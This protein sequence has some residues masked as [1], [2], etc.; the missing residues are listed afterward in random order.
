[1]SE[2]EG[3]RSFLGRWS[4]RKR[5]NEQVESVPAS[6]PVEADPASE[7]SP[8]V[9]GT[10]GEL[11]DS[12]LS[13][14]DAELIDSQNE[15]RALDQEQAE[16]PL[17]TDEDMPPIE[18]LS[19]DSDLSGFFSKGVSSALKRAA[20]RHV[21][22]QPQFNVRDGLNDYDGDYTVF[23][24][25]GDTVT[26]DMKWHIARKERERLEAEARELELQEHLEL[27]QKTPEG[28]DHEPEVDDEPEVVEDDVRLSE[29]EHDDAVVD[30]D[31]EQLSE[32]ISVLEH[33]DAAVLESAEAMLG[34]VDK[35]EL[36]PSR[37]AGKLT[38]TDSRDLQNDKK[39][40]QIADAK[41]GYKENAQDHEE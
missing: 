19:S 14:Q 27:E 23:E 11:T 26:S 40:L 31:E 1:M 9:E 17:L 7:L 38:R 16:L 13:V 37:V 28:Q 33:D 25:L 35:Q 3:Q 32:Q 39:T 36:S 4:A 5:Q 24:P 29:A 10:S 8:V 15:L 30:D 34:V 41:Q 6:V 2:Q 12:S 20:L 18:S 21:F 22:Q